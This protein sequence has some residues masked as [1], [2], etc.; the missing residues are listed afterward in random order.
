M[1]PQAKIRDVPGRWPRQ[2]NCGPVR[3]AKVVSP[4]LRT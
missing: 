1:F 2:R 3:I 4:G